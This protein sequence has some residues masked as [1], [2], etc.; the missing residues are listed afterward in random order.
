[1]HCLTTGLCSENCDTGQFLHCANII[2][3]VFTNLDVR[4]Y[5]TQVMQC[6]LLPKAT[7]LS[8][9]TPRQHITLLNTV[10]NWN[11]VVNICV[12][13]ERKYKY[14]LTFLWDPFR[15]CCPSL[16]ETSLCNT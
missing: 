5:Y 6:S 11:T 16:T 15:I 9:N 10:S 8:T 13:R 2:G 1:M 4:T 14:G 12:S 7:H 3:S